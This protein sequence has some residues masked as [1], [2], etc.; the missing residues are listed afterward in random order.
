MI[1]PLSPRR[2]K[3]EGDLPPL[4]PDCT[5]NSWQEKNMKNKLITQIQTSMASQLNVAQLEELGKVLTNALNC[6]EITEKRCPTANSAPASSSTPSPD[7]RETGAA[8]KRRPGQSGPLSR[9]QHSA[10]HSLPINDSV[11]LRYHLLFCE[12]KL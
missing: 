10:R 2:Q 12:N 4:L 7:H 11:F 8:S 6:V 1:P 5:T 3:N 9:D